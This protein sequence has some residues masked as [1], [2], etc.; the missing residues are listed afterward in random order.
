V[1]FIHRQLPFTDAIAER[2][3]HLLAGRDLAGRP[4]SF[5]DAAIAATA[6][7]HDIV[8]VTRNVKDFVDL[9]LDI[10]NPWTDKLPH[11]P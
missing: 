6:I 8:L 3:G 1:R 2:T 4:I 9:P 11:R 10:L 5:T 7:E